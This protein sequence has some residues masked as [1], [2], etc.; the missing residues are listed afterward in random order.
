MINPYKKNLAN[1]AKTNQA[2]KDQSDDNVQKK[3]L[4][5]DVMEQDQG[6]KKDYAPVE[7][8]QPILNL[9]SEISKLKIYHCILISFLIFISL[10]FQ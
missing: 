4:Q 10:I 9:E 3:V 7:K 6:F 8:I 1:Q 2:N 5:D